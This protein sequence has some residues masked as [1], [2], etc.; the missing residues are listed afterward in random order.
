VFTKRRFVGKEVGKPANSE[1]FAAALG[2]NTKDIGFD[3][4]KPSRWSAGVQ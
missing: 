2:L 1:T 4:F 3:T